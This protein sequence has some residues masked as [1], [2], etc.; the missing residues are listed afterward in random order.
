MSTALSTARSTAAST[1]RS[2]AGGASAAV[3]GNPYIV[4]NVGGSFVSKL[5]L[6]AADPCLSRC[7]YKLNY[8]KTLGG[9]CKIILL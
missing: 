9:I 8:Y 1:A 3:L 4:H 7:Y 5:E 6:G 2:T